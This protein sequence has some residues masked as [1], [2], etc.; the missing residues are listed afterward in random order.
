MS[1]L[2][3]RGALKKLKNRHPRPPPS[4]IP[5]TYSMWPTMK[6]AS[7]TEITNYYKNILLGDSPISFHCLILNLS[8]VRI[9]NIKEAFLYHLYYAIRKCRIIQNILMYGVNTYAPFEKQLKTTKDFKRPWPQL[10]KSSSSTSR[11]PGL[12]A[13]G[14]SDSEGSDR[15]SPRHMSLGFPKEITRK[16]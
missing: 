4:W 2:Q 10:Q 5:A 6:N 3:L 8:L 14:G 15:M 11:P 1:V 9:R 16:S 7:P 12:S 13:I